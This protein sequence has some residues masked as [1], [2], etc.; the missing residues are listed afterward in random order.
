MRGA[1]GAQAAM[2]AAVLRRRAAVSTCRYPSASPPTAVIGRGHIPM[3]IP[4][5]S[6][7]TIGQRSRRSAP[8]LRPAA[9]RPTSW[10]DLCDHSRR[11]LRVRT[12]RSARHRQHRLRIMPLRPQ[13]CACDARERSRSALRHAAKHRQHRSRCDC[14]ERFGLSARPANPH[15]ECSRRLRGRVINRNLSSTYAQDT[16]RVRH[17]LPIR[18][19]VGASIL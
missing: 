13:H 10:R 1:A 12:W 14:I 11:W 16:L 19:A 3:V 8:S 5:L 7:I 17:V 6:P 2:R 15:G 18:A 9:H 4:S